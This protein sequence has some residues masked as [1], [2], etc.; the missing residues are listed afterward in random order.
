MFSH[1]LQ[2]N[3]MQHNALRVFAKNICKFVCMIYLNLIK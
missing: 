1:L 3:N 2:V